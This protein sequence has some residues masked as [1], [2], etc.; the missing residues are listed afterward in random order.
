L[1]GGHESNEWLA[2]VAKNVA[3][4][5]R[6]SYQRP[7][8]DLFDRIKRDHLVFRPIYGEI[9]AVAE[10]T[11][12]VQEAMQ[13]TS[14]FP[15]DKIVTSWQGLNVCRK[16]APDAIGLND[17]DGHS[18]WQD[19]ITSLSPAPS[20]SEQIEALRP[21]WLHGQFLAVV[22]PYGLGNEADWFFALANSALK[23]PSGFGV[24]LIELHVSGDGNPAEW[25][26]QGASHQAIRS[27]IQRAKQ[28]LP[29]GAEIRLYVRAIKP[30]EPVKQQF[31]ARRLFAGNQ[32]NVGTGTPEMRIRWGIS[33]EHVA[34][35]GETPSQA[36]PTFTLLPRQQAD[37][38]YR[39]ECQNF[40]ARLAG[41][42]QVRC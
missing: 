5:K 27:F 37:D 18:F 1:N 7:A 24:P 28:A 19:V 2:V 36:P 9:R 32:V 42:I 35:I 25:K 10:E 13:P 26:S 30:R 23:R 17:L 6:T 41:P 14:S 38:Q 22:L 12:W 3:T 15:I 21:I 16:C 31:I 4:I 34:H 20:I 33:L 29:T 11:Q 8:M 39:F 40:S